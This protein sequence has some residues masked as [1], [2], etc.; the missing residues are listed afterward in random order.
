MGLK[1]LIVNVAC[2]ASHI[3][4]LIDRLFVSSEHK[5]ERQMEGIESTCVFYAY[6]LEQAICDMQLDKDRY[7]RHELSLTS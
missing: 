3:Q 5:R 4:Y 1:I 6:V 2:N 7:V